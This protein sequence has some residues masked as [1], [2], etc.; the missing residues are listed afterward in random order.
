MRYK[1]DKTPT[2]SGGLIRRRLISEKLSYYGGEVALSSG[3]EWVAG[4]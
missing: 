2:D 4:Y 1:Q 3:V